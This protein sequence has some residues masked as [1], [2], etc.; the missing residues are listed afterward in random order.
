MKLRTILATATAA[1]AFASAAFADGS[2]GIAMPTKSSARW[3]ADGDNMVKELE[4]AGY[5][6]DLQYAEDDIPNQLAQIE[7]MIT[8]GVDVLVI[9]AIDGTTLSNALENAAASGIHVI[10]YD[11]L[12]RDSENVD[13][14]ATFD[15]FKVGVQQASSLVSGLKERFGD[16]PYNV[17]LFG[18]SPDDNNAYFFYNGAM[19][20]LQPLIDAGTVNIASGQMGMDTVGTLRWDGA[21]AQA[22]MDNLLSAYYTDQD[23]HGVL[24]PYDGLSIGILSS[25]KGVG[26]GSGDMKM[27]IVSGQDAEVQ[28]V[29]SILAG[30]QYSTVFKDTR[31]LAKVTVG[32]VD[33]LL[34]GGEPE[35]ND[36]ETYDNGMKVVPS[37]LLEPVSVDASNWEEV[38]IGSGYYTEDQIK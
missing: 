9:A 20:V 23:V 14:Y 11:R 10:A 7:N 28:S 16:G 30:E 25:L 19:S 26:Y 33:A 31:E 35:I 36:T 12:I 21:V 27:P 17:E 13:Y 38:L 5:E 2:V 37:Y 1:I 29:K 3:I 6:A 4:K 22:R 8:K 24:S 18:G 15:N 34:A 32:M